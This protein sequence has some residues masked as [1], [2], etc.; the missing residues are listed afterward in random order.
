MVGKPVATGRQ[1]KHETLKRYAGS[2]LRAMGCASVEMEYPILLPET[3]S[4][5]LGLDSYKLAD[6]YGMPPIGGPFVVECGSVDPRQEQKLCELLRYYEI[7]R[8]FGWWHHCSFIIE[9]TES[10]GSLFPIGAYKYIPTSD[11]VVDIALSDVVRMPSL[12]KNRSAKV[13]QRSDPV[14]SISADMLRR[15]VGY[16]GLYES[17]RQMRLSGKLLHE[18]AEEHSITRQRVHQILFSIERSVRRSQ[19]GVS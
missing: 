3:K 15:A 16:V 6:V 8:L 5:S 19:Q 18:I 11:R 10:G 13:S 1:Y 17:V 9:Y 14:H 7:R 4:V 2:F 12:R